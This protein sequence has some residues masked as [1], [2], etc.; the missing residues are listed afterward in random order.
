MKL[1]CI[2][3]C[4]IILGSCATAS[5]PKV[6][7]A[8]FGR[9]I[10]SDGQRQAG[11]LFQ[12]GA[13]STPVAGGSL[14]AFGDTF[15]G[16]PAPGDLPDRSQIKGATGTTI[17]FLPAGETNLPPRLKYFSGADGLAT[18][19]LALFP[20]EPAATNRMWPLGGIAVGSHIYLYYSMIE[21]TDGP[22]PWNFRGIGGGLAVADEPLQS[23]TRLRPGGHWKFPVE[24]IQI[25]REGP[26]LYLFEISSTP[27][28]LILARVRADD[29]EKPAAYEF[30][31]GQ[32]W[33]TNRAQVTVILREAYGQVSVVWSP[34]RRSYL[35]AT[36]SDFFH[37]REIQLREAAHLEGP[38]G[39]PVR[40]AVPD[41]PGKTT[42]LIYGAFLH[43]ELSDDQ[44]GRYLVTYCRMLSGEWE[45]TNPEWVS[46]TLAP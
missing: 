35:M 32:G 22:G 9:S 8:E 24:P 45:L 25:V 4:A 28:G 21:K 38:W 39:K 36:S 30:F 41:M 11:V 14:W 44:A 33:S 12:D 2:F 15:F 19:P 5:P 1:C 34:A 31:T 26:L 43:P 17:A 18:N 3:L 42:K 29:I 7:R 10:W 27:K 37:P 20:E 23:F 13:Q 46:L 40:V 16:R 6:L